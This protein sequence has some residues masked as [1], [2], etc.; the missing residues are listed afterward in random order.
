MASHVLQ[1]NYATF[2]SSFVQE[3]GEVSDNG[4]I[5]YVFSTRSFPSAFSPVWYPI[6]NTC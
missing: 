3:M 5:F 2:A 6:S 1:L 4:L